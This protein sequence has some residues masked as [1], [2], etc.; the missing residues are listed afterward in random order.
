MGLLFL[1]VF[2]ALFFSFICSIA[3]AVLLSMTPS[4]IASLEKKKKGAGKLLN[5]LNENIDR[6]IAA[7]LSLNTMAHTVGA[8]GAGA[9]AAVVFGSGYV[10]VSSAVLTLLILI[11]SEIIPKTL[12]A[13]YWRGL[14]PMVGRGVWLLIILLYPLV[15]LSEK[16]TRFFSRDAPSG[17]FRSDEFTALAELGMKEGALESQ[18]SRILKNLF[19]L[20]QL[21]AKDIM[22]HRP[23]VFS[24]QEEMSIGDALQKHPEIPFSRIPLYRENHDDITGFVLKSDMLL[25]SAEGRKTESLK[26]HKR[27]IQA[28]PETLLLSKLYDL[29]LDAREHIV[30]VVDEY[31]G[32]EGIV[33]LEDVLETLLGLEI[34]DEGD[35]TVDMQAFARS[36]WK[37][38]AAKLGIIP[39]EEDDRESGKGEKERK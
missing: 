27:P 3:E 9:Q 38:R 2:I 15:L 30:I 28:I 20:R 7:I 11:L 14:A 35:R 39:E 18:E 10:G 32:M 33:T 25:A 5:T 29:L 8:V 21:K 37:M 16:L 13:T 24:L 26:A 36:R 34:V 17:A 23:V 1:Y 19:R 12:G 4:Y 6:P 22:T 31:G